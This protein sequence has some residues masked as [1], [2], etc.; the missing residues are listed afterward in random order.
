MQNEIEKMET[1]G[2]GHFRARL[3]QISGV[4]LQQNAREPRWPQEDLDP[5][6]RKGRPPY[7]H[8]SCRHEAMQPSV[9]SP[10]PCCVISWQQRADKGHA[11]KNHT[12]VVERK[13]WARNM[14]AVG[15]WGQRKEHLGAMHDVVA[16]LFLT[17]PAVVSFYPSRKWR[18]SAHLLCF[19]QGSFIRGCK[20]LGKCHIKSIKDTQDVTRDFSLAGWIR[21]E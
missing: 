14:R 12:I 21:G 3:D 15:R 6:R 2:D 10:L 11:L 4:Q 17:E 9:L 16:D 20:I 13:R 7:S 8:R 19:T 18:W 1:S 5:S